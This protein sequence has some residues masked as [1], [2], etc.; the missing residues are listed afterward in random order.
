MEMVV[1]WTPPIGIAVDYIRA[2]FRAGVEAGDLS[3]AC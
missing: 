3:I 2:A 1:V